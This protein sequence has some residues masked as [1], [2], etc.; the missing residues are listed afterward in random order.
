M[1]I[2]AGVRIA[3]RAM[4][5]YRLRA[6]FM[7]L[8]LII[9]ISSLTALYSVGENAKQETT[10]RFKNMLGTFDTVMV[11]PGAGRTRG[12]PSLT[13]VEPTL[14]FEDAAA[15][16]A[17]VP[18]IK[19]VATL[20]SAFDVDVKYRDRSTA[21]AVF[22][23]SPNWLQLRGDEMSEGDFFS[24]EDDQSLARVAV[25]GLDVKTAL[26][27]ADDPVGKTLRIGDVPFQVKGVL[28]SRGAGPAGASLDNI[29][30]I[31]ITTA[32]KRLF[33]RDF[34]TMLVAQL[35]N[36]QQGDAA[37]AGITALLRRRHRIVP[38]GQDDFTVTNPRAVMAQVTQVGTTLSRTLTG[39]AA[40]AML[41]GGVVIMSLM[42]I[43][44]A[45][46]RREIGVRRSFGATRRDIL[47]QFMLEALAV[48]FAGGVTGVGLALAGTNLVA[49]LQNLPAIFAWNVL[50]LAI[51]LSVS[52]GLVFGLYPAWKAARVDPVVAL[53]S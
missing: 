40:I 52:V 47:V 43:A 15:V 8:G 49:R 18:E 44:V 31:P 1:G 46:R 6:F 35:R 45:E 2:L 37:V 23:A 21:C 50:G 25:V 5:R 33:N 3:F 27:P 12:M 19:Q 41:I 48:S 34:I 38:A 24:P 13:N 7:M 36:P 26:F 4:G 29:V 32:S 51:G 39:V 20:Q 28:K 16:R 10:R 11:R 42:L 22:G 30:M 53:R 9:G 14:K 17:E